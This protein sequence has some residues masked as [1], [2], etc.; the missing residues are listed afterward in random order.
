MP[1]MRGFGTVFR[2]GSGDSRSFGLCTRCQK[3]ILPLLLRLESEFRPSQNGST[4]RRPTAFFPL[5]SGYC[6]YTIRLMIDAERRANGD[7]IDIREISKDTF[8]LKDYFKI[9]VEDIRIQLDKLGHSVEQGVVEYKRSSLSPLFRMVEA[10]QYQTPGMDVIEKQVRYIQALLYVALIQRL[11]AEGTVKL[12]REKIQEEQIK[13]SDLNLKD[14]L[15]DVNKRIK[16]NP[17]A[18]KDPSVKKILMQVGIYKK[19]QETMKKLLPTIKEDSKES[20]MKNFRN[21][22]AEIIEKIK[23][24]YLDILLEENPPDTENR[25]ILARL[26]LTELVPVLTSQCQKISK[27]RS[28]LLFVREEKYKTREVLGGLS[29]EK[30][31][32]MGLLDREM[33]AYRDFG[34]KLED[35]SG[36][37]A[38]AVSRAMCHELIDFLEKELSFQQS[39]G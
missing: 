33:A 35:L 22:F 25:N 31:A 19:E 18:G 1:K 20:F 6:G 3:A 7:W 26:P 17:E 34:E 24:S 14:I 23:R 28:I 13:T 21:T 30:D 32:V 29:R 8:A 36:D 16:E 9:P 27:T 37:R 38:S 4:R 12:T 39:P 10:S 2:R 5:I 15:Q 11:I